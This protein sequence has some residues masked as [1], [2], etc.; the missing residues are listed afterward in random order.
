[1]SHQVGA[2][3]GKLEESFQETVLA[4]LALESKDCVTEPSED[5][6]SVFK[7]VVGSEFS[8]IASR[9]RSIYMNWDGSSNPVV[10]VASR[11]S[12]GW[13]IGLKGHI[14]K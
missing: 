10:G 4:D 7:A 12:L 1:L 5:P 14:W 9:R 2:D 3:Q 8:K 6:L 11:G 13:Q